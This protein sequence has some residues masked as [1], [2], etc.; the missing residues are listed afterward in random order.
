[1][2]TREAIADEL[3]AMNESE[4]DYSGIPPMTEEER[5][6]V[7]PYYKEFLEKL[8]ADMAKELARRRLEETGAL[9]EV[10]K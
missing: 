9:S 2:K 6:T 10:K 5:Q 8:P 1:L 7:Q 3:D 4:I